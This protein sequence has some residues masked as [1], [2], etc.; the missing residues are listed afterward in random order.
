[1]STTWII[2]ICVIAF[3]VLLCFLLAIANFSYDRFMQRYKEIDK[4]PI[5]SGMTTIEFISQINYYVFQNKL[6]ILQISQ[7][8]GDAYGNGKLFLST[9]TINSNSLASLTIIAHELGH[10][11]QDIEGGKLKRL[12]FLRYLGKALGF[13]LP[14]CL[15]AGIILLFLGEDYFTIGLILLGVGVGIFLLAL[16]N[17]LLTIS[18]E[19]DASSKAIIFLK[20]YLTEGELRKAKRFLKDARLTY[21]ADF[22]RII[23]GWT[24]ISKKSKLF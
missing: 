6:K 5:Q 10:A 17:K 22:L 12:K 19:K 18:I 23:L 24:G 16:F 13:I 21:W 11:K 15:I 8:A 9:R 3:A 14:L 4:I 2:I 7:V 20:D 1:M